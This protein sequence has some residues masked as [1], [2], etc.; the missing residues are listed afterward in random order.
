VKTLDEGAIRWEKN[1]GL[2]VGEMLRMA[3]DSFE[4]H[5]EELVR[6]ITTELVCTTEFARGND[7][8]WVYHPIYDLAQLSLG[9]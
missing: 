4:L 8:K 9:E 2:T 7:A 1:Y 6:T 5:R 3:P